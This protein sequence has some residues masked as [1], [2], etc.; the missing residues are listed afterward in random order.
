[1]A[2]TVVGAARRPVGYDTFDDLTT[3]S[4][5]D[6][7]RDR[8]RVELV[9]DGELTTTEAQAIW[10]RLTSADDADEAARAVLRSASDASNRWDLLCAYVLGDPMPDPIYPA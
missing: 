3:R 7:R 9:F 5:L 1:M 4:L 2:A 10:Q 6:I 8:G